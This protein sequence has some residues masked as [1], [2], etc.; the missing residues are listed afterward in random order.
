MVWPNLQ[1]KWHVCVFQFN[2]FRIKVTLVCILEFLLFEVGS[3]IY[4]K[5]INEQW[6]LDLIVFVFS[7]CIALLIFLYEYLTFFHHLYVICVPFLKHSEEPYCRQRLLYTWWI[8]E[9]NSGNSINWEFVVQYGPL[10]NLFPPMLPI[11]CRAFYMLG[12]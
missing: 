7:G 3:Q 10:R 9:V 1:F 6:A 4:F 5:M 2:T 8:A 11:E 12:N